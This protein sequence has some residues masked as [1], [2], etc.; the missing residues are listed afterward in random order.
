MTATQEVQLLKHSMAVKDSLQKCLF[1]SLQCDK[2]T[3][4]RNVTKY[5]YRDGGRISKRRRFAVNFFSKRRP[6]CHGWFCCSLH[7][8]ILKRCWISELFSLPLYHTSTGIMYKSAAL[9]IRYENCKFYSSQTTSKQK[10]YDTN[11]FLLHRIKLKQNGLLS[12]PLK[13][14]QPWKS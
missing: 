11:R 8:V 14:A 9:W 7:H 10:L 2:S 1:L 13:V 4:I 5:F 3:D 12:N 6:P